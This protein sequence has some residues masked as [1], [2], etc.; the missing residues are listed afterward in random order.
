V[1]LK[2]AMFNF[3]F[4]TYEVPYPSIKFEVQVNKSIPIHLSYE[5]EYEVT[6]W[7]PGFKRTSFKIHYLKSSLKTN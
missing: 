1:T 5:G 2:N 4:L 6:I 7:A 3:R